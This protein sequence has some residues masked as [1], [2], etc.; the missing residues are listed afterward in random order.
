[1]A[2]ERIHY[3]QR[4]RGLDRRVGDACQSLSLQIR[5]NSRN[6]S[7]QT[8]RLPKLPQTQNYLRCCSLHIPCMFSGFFSGFQNVLRMSELEQSMHIFSTRLA[9]LALAAFACLV[10]AGELCVL[11]ANIQ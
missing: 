9:G 11:I 1:M 3:Y 8:W 6:N 7:G 10:R 4:A 5:Q 2:R